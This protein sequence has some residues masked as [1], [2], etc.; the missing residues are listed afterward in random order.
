MRLSRSDYLALAGTTVPLFTTLRRREQVPRLRNFFPLK[1]PSD[2]QEDAA[3]YLP[4]EAVFLALSNDLAMDG[5]LDRSLASRL[6]EGH[7]N[8]LVPA[9]RRAEAGEEIWFGHAAFRD[10]DGEG[11]FMGLCEAGALSEIVE[12]LQAFSY[13][14]GFHPWPQVRRLTVVNVTRA[15]HQV[16]AR[17]AERGLTLGA[18]A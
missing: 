4:V 8:L 13:S 12:A 7:P 6:V 15:V 1:K 14:D 11:E 2:E 16:H 18:I 17:A 10:A 5:G 9:V 3:G